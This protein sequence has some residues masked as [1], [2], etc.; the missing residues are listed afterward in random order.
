M[1]LS[2]VISL[3][4]GNDVLNMLISA[5]SYNGNE[6]SFKLTLECWD[7]DLE[8]LYTM[9]ADLYEIDGS[10]NYIFKIDD[11]TDKYY[12]PDQFAYAITS[13]TQ[14][15]K[16]YKSVDE[17]KFDTALEYLGKMYSFGKE[18]Y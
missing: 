12:L 15:W 10:V 2:K 9:E 13:I 6:D 17:E 1:K 8:T 16:A 5:I 4:E 14:I 3:F 7:E 18:D 11:N